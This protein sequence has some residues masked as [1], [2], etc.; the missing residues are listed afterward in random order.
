MASSYWKWANGKVQPSYGSSVRQ[1]LLAW[2]IL[3]V[4]LHGCKCVQ[5]FTFD[6]H[7]SST[8]IEEGHDISFQCQIESDVDVRSASSFWENRNREILYPQEFIHVA[9]QST[10]GFIASNLTIQRVGRDLEDSYRC[11]V[12]LL[13][14]DK[15]IEIVSSEFGKLNVLHFPGE[16]DMNCQTQDGLAVKAGDT[17]TISCEAIRCNLPL[18]INW[19]RSNLMGL[20]HTVLAHESCSMTWMVTVD[21]KLQNEKLYCVVTSPSFPG[22]RSNCSLGPYNV[23][24]PPEVQVAPRN[25][26]VLVPSIAASTSLYCLV[27]ANPPV[28]IFKW[29]CS[30]EGFLPTCDFAEQNITIPLSQVGLRNFS[31]DVTCTATNQIGSSRNTSKFTVGSPLV[32]AGRECSSTNH[33]NVSDIETGIYVFQSLTGDVYQFTCAFIE[34]K[35]TSAFFKWYLDGHQIREN[36]N[37]S[38]GQ[39][40]PWLRTDFLV[41]TNDILSAE[42]THIVMCE[43]TTETMVKVTSCTFT[44]KFDQT[45][46]RSLHE[47]ITR[48]PGLSLRTHQGEPH[49]VSGVRVSVPSK[50]PADSSFD[51]WDIFWM[52]LIAVG[53]GFVLVMCSISLV[54]IVQ[55]ATRRGRLPFN[56]HSDTVQLTNLQQGIFPNPK[57][58]GSD[59]PVYE[60]PRDCSIRRKSSHKPLPPRPKQEVCELKKLKD[61]GDPEGSCSDDYSGVYEDSSQGDGD[62]STSLV[63]S[64]ETSSATQYQEYAECERDVDFVHYD[65][66]QVVESFIGDQQSSYYRN[67]SLAFRELYKYDVEERVKMFASEGSL[68]NIQRIYLE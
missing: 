13:L 64:S 47:T 1:F 15:R 60:Q 40:L 33:R 12:L 54:L 65:N 34:E 53:V 8:R 44:S 29:S 61:D 42:D 49:S 68:R 66:H 25:S 32:G 67:K 22:R 21:R 4:Y 57:G 16:D 7:P 28:N 48:G 31:V 18:D 14:R 10:N 5:M 9:T 37:T 46:T 30:P 20:H 41:L 11:T 43:I 45:S 36:N 26:E 51:F 62:N 58:A 24:Y 3:S 38:V 50:S 17:V 35:E 39:I 6:I 23:L 19:E 52:L 2:I 55:R 56:R 63:S 27:D 59:E